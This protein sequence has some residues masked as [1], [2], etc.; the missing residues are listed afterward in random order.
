MNKTIIVLLSAVIL[1]AS[2]A[3]GYFAVLTPEQVKTIWQ[4]VGPLALAMLG[5]QNAAVTADVKEMK[6]RMLPP[7]EKKA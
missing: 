5:L 7:P 3:L 6:S 4:I 2:G 1:L